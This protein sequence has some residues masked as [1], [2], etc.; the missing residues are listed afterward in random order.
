M[1]PPDESALETIEK[2]NRVGMD[3]I[4]SEVI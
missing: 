4:I 1:N 2:I 3:E